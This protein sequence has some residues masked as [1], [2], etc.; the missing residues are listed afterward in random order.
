MNWQFFATAGIVSG[1]LWVVALALFLLAVSDLFSWDTQD[2]L[3]VITWICFLLPIAFWLVVGVICG[4]NAIW[5][6][7]LVQS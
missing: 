5:D 3:N 2:V 1:V 4:L 7:G 6:W